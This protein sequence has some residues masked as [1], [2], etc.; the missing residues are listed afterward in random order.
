MGFY[1]YDYISVTGIKG[2]DPPC[3]KIRFYAPN[4]VMGVIDFTRDVVG[5]DPNAQYRLGIS[6]GTNDSTLE[7]EITLY[8]SEDNIIGTT[9]TTAKISR[10]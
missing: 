4:S 8:D 10:Y 1:S 5:P 2:S 7:V 9:T 3:A 6:S